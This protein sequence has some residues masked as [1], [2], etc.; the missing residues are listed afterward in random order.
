MTPKE[1]EK[2]YNSLMRRATKLEEEKRDFKKSVKE[3]C[4]HPAEYLH[5]WKDDRDDGYGRWWQ[6][7]VCTCYICGK[8][9]Y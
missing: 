2:K 9:L 1:I 5:K 8:Q 4:H 7:E 6:V 3:I